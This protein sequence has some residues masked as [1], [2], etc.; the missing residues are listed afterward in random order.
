MMG[1]TIIAILQLAGQS[2]VAP[3][4]DDPE[5]WVLEY[6][7]LIKPY[8]DDYYGC[9]RSR[10]VTATGEELSVFETQHRAHLPLCANKLAKAKK[11][12]NEALEGRSRYAEYT[13]ERI[14]AVFQTID[15]IHVERGRD[16]DNRLRLHLAKHAEYDRAYQQTPEEVSGGKRVEADLPAQSTQTPPAQDTPNAQN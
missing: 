10:G 8:V 14:G 7:I 15:I 16:L 5:T 2:V 11:E 12:A 13:P 4:P 6:P 9:L 3:K 1:T